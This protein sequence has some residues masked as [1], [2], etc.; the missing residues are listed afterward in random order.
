MRRAPGVRLW[1]GLRGQPFY[2]GAV[3]LWDDRV[4][5]RH[6]DYVEI[7]AIVG[8]D[9][10]HRID[11][12][13]GSSR[14]ERLVPGQLFLFRPRDQ[15]ALIGLEPD[16]VTVVHVAFPIP[17]WHA[18]A[19]LAAL[20][21]GW[22][23]AT[24]PPSVT[25]TPGDPAVLRPFEIAIERYLDRPVENDLIRFWTDIVPIL[26][27]S[28][29]GRSSGPTPAWLTRSIEALRDERELRGGVT[30]LRELS[31]VSATHLGRAVRQHFGMTPT[32]LVGQFQVERAAFLLG[33]T[34]DSIAMISDRCGFSS[35][36]Y[37]SKRFRESHGMS[38]REYRRHWSSTHPEDELIGSLL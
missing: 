3:T 20:G 25:F 37:F 35:P 29:R 4:S 24:A 34:Q 38:P 5:H 18:F 14:T 15:H 32:D 27:P 21:D 22:S 10:L 2:A 1:A 13:D 30:R 16:G 28:T 26:V 33:T 7:M 8:G 11:S 12:D 17:A 19:A 31:H 36:S 6:H 9:G 23:T